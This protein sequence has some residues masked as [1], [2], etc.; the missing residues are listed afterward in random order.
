KTDVNLRQA[1]SQ[2]AKDKITLIISQKVSIIRDADKI[3]V[4]EDNG[5]VAGLGNHDTLM[6]TSPLYA[7]IVSS[8]LK[9]VSE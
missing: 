2:Y 7:S 5:S 9:E 8:Q 6:E 1:L 4:L 3:L